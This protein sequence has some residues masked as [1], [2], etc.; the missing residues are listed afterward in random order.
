L[1]CENQHLQSE[2]RLHVNQNKEEVRQLREDGLKTQNLYAE[3]RRLYD[4]SMRKYETLEKEYMD[5]KQ[6]N[7]ELHERASQLSADLANFKSTE[8]EKKI[9]ASKAALNFVPISNSAENIQRKIRI[10]NSASSEF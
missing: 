6:E 10:S 9:S 1:E 2:L 4:R 8:K 5:L 3:I 7:K